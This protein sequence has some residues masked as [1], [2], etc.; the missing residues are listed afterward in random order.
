MLMQLLQALSDQKISV[1]DVSRQLTDLSFSDM[2]FAKVDHHRSLRTGYPEV[3]FCQNK[4]PEHIVGIVQRQMEHGETVFGTRA[5]PQ[6]LAAVSSAF[7]QLQIN[8]IGRCFWHKSEHWHQRGDTLGDIVIVSAGTADAP[9]TEEARCTVEVLGHSCVC[10][11]DAGVAGIHRLFAH[12]SQLMAASVII[13]IAGM[14]G[15]LPS[16]IAGLVS[17]PVIGVPTSVGYGAHLNGM[18]PL[19]AM[20][21]SCAS[22]LTVVNI[23][24]GFGAAFAAA[25]MNTR[26]GDHGAQAGSQSC[27]SQS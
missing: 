6:A 18:V 7:P 1:E 16:V 3:I 15:A 13:A 14:E 8:P 2:G 23:D 27:C 9:M 20:L 19:F 25:T 24:N 22:G 12:K 17:C 26:R 21:N 11:Q 4:A 10:I 5:S